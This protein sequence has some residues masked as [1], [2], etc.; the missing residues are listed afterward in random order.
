MRKTKTYTIYD[1]QEGNVTIS[2]KTDTKGFYIGDIGDK[3]KRWI[4]IIDIDNVIKLCQDLND[5]LEETR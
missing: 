1:N 3:D 2:Y 5:F 4:R